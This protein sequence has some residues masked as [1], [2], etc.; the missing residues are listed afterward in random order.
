M[1]FRA[2]ESTI[3]LFEF[4]TAENDITSIETFLRK[5]EAFVLKTINKWQILKAV[6]TDWSSVFMNSILFE[7]NDGI[8]IR[9]YLDVAWS[10]LMESKPMPPKTI[11]I[12]TCNAHLLRRIEKDIDKDM[13]ELKSM[14]NFLM[15]CSALI[16]MCR[17]MQELDVVFDDILHV[18]LERDARKLRLHSCIYQLLKI[19]VKKKLKMLLKI[20]KKKSCIE[21]L[22]KSFIICMNL[23]TP[24][25]KIPNFMYMIYILQMKIWGEL[26]TRNFSFLVYMFWK[27]TFI[28]SQIWVLSSRL[29]DPCL[30]ISIVLL[31]TWVSIVRSF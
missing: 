10:Y 18:I 8:S 17:T 23:A 26:R 4:I 29:D 14:K 13:P 1:V 2:R 21:K 3:A 22:K 16:I 12:L 20:Q 24:F 5:F 27:E 25:T 6:V 30:S 11:F 7:W 28:T 9:D 19:K 15:E 31:S